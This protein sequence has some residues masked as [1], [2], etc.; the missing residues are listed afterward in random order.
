[1]TNKLKIYI[2]RLVR[3]AQPTVQYCSICEGNALS[4]ASLSGY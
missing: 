4:D 3:S 2:K 1:M